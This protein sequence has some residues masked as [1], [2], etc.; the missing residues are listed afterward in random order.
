MSNTQ[1]F[2]SFREGEPSGCPVE[3]IVRILERNGCTPRDGEAYDFSIQDPFYDEKFFALAADLVC[4][5]GLVTFRE[6]GSGTYINNASLQPHSPADI[7]IGATVIQSKADLIAAF[8]A[9]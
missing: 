7:S 8:E 2:D 4:E 1:F 5:L 9:N 3:P 6:I